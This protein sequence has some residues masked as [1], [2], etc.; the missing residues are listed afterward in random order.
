MYRIYLNHILVM[1]FGVLPDSYCIAYK[2]FREAVQISLLK[3]FYDLIS[4]LLSV[5]RIQD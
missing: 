3:H 2:A 5:F 4:G 1:L